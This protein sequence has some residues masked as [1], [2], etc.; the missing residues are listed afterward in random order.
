MVNLFL[1]E[2]GDQPEREKAWWGDPR[3]SLQQAC[4]R[5]MFTLE[6]EDKRDSHQWVFSKADLNAIGTQIASHAT[7]LENAGTFDDLYKAIA[8][9]LGLNVHRKPLLIYDVAQRLGYRFERYPQEVYL[10]AGAKTGAQA[11]RQG[12]G[13]PRCRPLDDFPTS[14]R[15]RLTPSQAEDFLCLASTYLRPELWD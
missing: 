2:R 14:I 10:H 12:L 9:A 13:R 15:T 1:S 7:A 6:N 4:Q 8:G 11:L 3:L 5:A